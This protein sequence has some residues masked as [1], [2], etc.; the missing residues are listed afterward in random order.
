MGCGRSYVGVAVGIG[1]VWVP[2]RVG[3]GRVGSSTPTLTWRVARVAMVASVEEHV[4]ARGAR[5]VAADGVVV[6][7]ADSAAAAAREGSCIQL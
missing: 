3:S 6:A 7:K 1:V 5:M 2:V 4:E